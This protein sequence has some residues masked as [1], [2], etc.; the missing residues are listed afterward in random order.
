MYTV[1]VSFALD[2][3]SCLDSISGVSYPQSLDS[4][5]QLRSD[6]GVNMLIE[7]DNQVHPIP[8]SSVL[9]STSDVIRGYQEDR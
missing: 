2:F 1:P 8:K 9:V 7:V 4:C 5:E 6:Q 3:Q